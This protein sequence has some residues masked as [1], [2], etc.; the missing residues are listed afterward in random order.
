MAGRSM[1]PVAPRVSASRANATAAAVV[2]SDTP[3][4]TGTRPR[5]ASTAVRSTERFSSAVS[6]LFSPTVPNATRPC[7]PSSMSADWTAR[8]AARSTPRSA[9]N[10][11]VT[12]GSTPDQEQ[13]DADC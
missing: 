5:A 11:V 2:S 3:A 1:S 9:S 6:E 7:T 13:V 4:T 12:A 10:W 8:V